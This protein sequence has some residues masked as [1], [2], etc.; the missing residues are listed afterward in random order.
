VVLQLDVDPFVSIEVQLA[1][2]RGRQV[3]QL[4]LAADRDPD[5]VRRR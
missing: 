5:V 1:R 4:V 2:E 3:Y